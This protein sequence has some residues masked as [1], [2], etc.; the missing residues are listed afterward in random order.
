MKRVYTG[1]TIQVI[2]LAHRSQILSGSFQSV[3]S[4]FTEVIDQIQYSG[5]GVFDAR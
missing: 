2:Q 5:G 1:S 4:N 3:D